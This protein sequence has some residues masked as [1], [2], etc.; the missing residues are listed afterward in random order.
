MLVCPSVN[1]GASVDD[2]SMEPSAA[3]PLAH[4]PCAGAVHRRGQA[5]LFAGRTDP[6]SGCAV[7]SEPRWDDV[8]QLLPVVADLER[9]AVP[10]EQRLAVRGRSLNGQLRRFAPGQCDVPA[11]RHGWLVDDARAPTAT[12]RS[13]SA[14]ILGGPGFGPSE[15][16]DETQPDQPAAERS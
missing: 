15:I 10:A 9:P 16:G 7:R 4:P 14:R 13:G 12:D 2:A 1:G 5:H 3:K 6:T 11:A 8:D